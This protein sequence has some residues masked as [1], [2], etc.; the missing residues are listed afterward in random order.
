M[1]KLFTLIAVA[2]MSAG[3]MSAQTMVIKI[4]GKE[5]KNGDDV[6]INKL[7][8][9]TVLNPALKMYDLGV[10]VE[11]KTLVAQTVET[12]GID[13]DQ[14]TPGLACC[15]T[16]FTCT[17]ANATNNWISTGTMNDMEAG[18][19][20]NGEWIHYNYGSNNKPADGI[21]RKSK[22]TFKGASETIT[23]NLTINNTS[24]GINEITAEENENALMYNISGQPVNS[25]Y[26]G[27]VVKKGKKYTTK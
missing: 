10:N 24:T 2:L 11:F 5:V 1:K 7:A 23:F 13:L 12:E 25:D 6:V 26:K 27:I 20:V 8:N 18:R 14:I 16:G 19:E 22:I 4:E 3:S 15:P 9:E 17:T 21:S